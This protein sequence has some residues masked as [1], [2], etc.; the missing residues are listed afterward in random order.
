MKQNI[1]DAFSTNLTQQGKT[2]HEFL[3]WGLVYCYSTLGVQY[4]SSKIW[5]SGY[6]PQKWHTCC[7][8]SQLLQ[9][10]EVTSRFRTSAKA[11]RHSGT[12]NV[13][14]VLLH[15]YLNKTMKSKS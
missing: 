11:K 14:N 4:S 7:N 9:N 12:N 3:S 15:V 10:S 2:S 6:P 5:I 1:C 8:P 13:Q